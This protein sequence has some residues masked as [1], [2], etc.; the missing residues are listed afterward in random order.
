MGE[1]GNKK[2]NLLKFPTD[3]FL[4]NDFWK[5]YP[6]KTKIKNAYTWFK[7]TP[8]NQELLN[9][10][11]E[12]ISRQSKSELWSR[13]LGR[14]IPDA[15]NWLKSESWNDEASFETVEIDPETESALDEI[16]RKL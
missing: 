13:E 7:T 4:F 6:K 2:N 9:Q 3:N 8:V 5:T 12:A 1:V 16:Y 15:I 10:M 11:I 14:Y